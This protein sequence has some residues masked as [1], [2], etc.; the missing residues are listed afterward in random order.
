MKK[1]LFLII[2]LIVASL[3]SNAGSTP[4]IKVYLF[5]QTQCP[6]VYSHTETFGAMI[7]Q[8]S[9]QVEFVA[10][11][12]EVK[13]TDQKIKNL[14]KDLGWKIPYIKDSQHQ[15]VKRMQPK[16][17]TDCVFVDASGKTLY[18]GAIDDG[19]ANM[20]TVKHFYLKDALDAYFRQMPIL[21]KS[22]PG[23][24]C[25]LSAK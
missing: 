14:L 4:K 2:A 10:V 13:D 12:T 21:V 19:P 23:R 25:F 5:L 11:F 1:I 3:P 20:G 9:H 6:C 18:N 24:G 15:L 22:E 17:S 7:K 16:L 8:Y